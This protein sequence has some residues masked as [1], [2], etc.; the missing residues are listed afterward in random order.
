V[1]APALALAAVVLAAGCGGS[2]SQEPSPQSLTIR[3]VLAR[4]GPNVQLIPGDGDFAPGPVRYSFLVVRPNGAQVDTQRARV[5]VADSTDSKPFATTMAR[6]EPVGVPGATTDSGDV[7]HLYVAH[8]RVPKTG[9][10]VLAAEP[11]GGRSIQGASELQV[12]SRSASPAVGAQAISSRTPTLASTGG[13]VAAL[14]TRQP[15]DRG[16]LRY[17]V[18]DSLAAHA[19][20]VL[21]FATPKLCT[22]RTCGPVVDVVQNVSRRF[23]GRGVRF[24]HVEVYTDNDPTKGYNRWMREWHLPS[25]PW[26]FLVGRDGRIKAKFEGSVSAGELAAAVREHLLS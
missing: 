1:R 23:R 14:T 2:K 6:L 17:S 26:T 16:L 4:P 18:A 21:T 19:P 22:S 13:N 15:P 24:I 9:T 12:K 8:F 11:V 7:S 5:F 20:F 25:E 10:Y 3:S